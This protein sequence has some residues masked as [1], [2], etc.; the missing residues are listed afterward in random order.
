M[1][2]QRYAD[3]RTPLPRN[4]W[5]IGALSEEIGEAL[6]ERWLVGRNILFYRKKNGDAVALHNRCPHRS[7][8]LSRG[9]REG[10]AVVCGYHGMT[11]AAD[12][13]CVR[14]PSQE[15]AVGSLRTR[16]YPVV[17]RKPFV[18]IW[19]GEGVAPNVEPPEIPWL[20]NPRY[21][22]VTGVF[23]VA[24]SYVRL[25]ENV[26]DLSHLSYLHKDTL[27]GFDIL[28][29]PEITETEGVVRVL[30][31]ALGVR[32]PGTDERQPEQ[33]MDLR[34]VSP[35]VHV[36]ENIA[37]FPESPEGP[38]RRTHAGYVHAFTP[39]DQTRTRYFWSVSR[40][41][42]L[43]DAEL[44]ATVKANFS[45]VLMQDIE[46]LAYVEDIWAREDDD[47]QEINVVAD[48]AG[49]RMRRIVQDYAER[50]AAARVAAE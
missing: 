28:E 39:I 36:A 30:L 42:K 11:F 8:P 23:D 7:Y 2:S 41:E 10:D 22:D 33:T 40:D 25:H 6:T 13:R 38:A 32:R 20:G 1:M 17:E 27:P 9:Y 45:K 14:I 21:E 46:G 29:R 15:G 26:L 47:F 5:Y 50:E 34:F 35:A 31:K 4:H 3:H 37:D 44:N 16:V 12:G 18:W 19:M 48:R 24:C 43:G 49:L